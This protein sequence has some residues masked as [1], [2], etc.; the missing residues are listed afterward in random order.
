MRAFRTRIPSGVSSGGISIPCPSTI[1][2]NS[3]HK[4]FILSS[5]ILFIFL[6]FQ[7]LWP[8]GY[9]LICKEPS[10]TLSPSHYCDELEKRGEMLA[11]SSP[12]KLLTAYDRS[13][14]TGADNKCAISFVIVGANFFLHPNCFQTQK[15]F[16]RKLHCLAIGIIRRRSG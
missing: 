6:L 1:S 13:H 2:T 9:G 4:L 16:R 12:E 8:S 14:G 5:I 10:F 7:K 3:C 15:L 11:Q